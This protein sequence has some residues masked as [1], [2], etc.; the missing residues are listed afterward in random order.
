VDEF[1]LLAIHFEYESS[2]VFG[3]VGDRPFKSKI[4]RDNLSDPQ[5]FAAW[6]KRYYKRKY[7]LADLTI[8]PPSAETWPT[9]LAQAALRG[10]Q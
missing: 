8:E 2:T 10:D 5:R 9:L 4:S 1:R 3:S 7:R 6:L